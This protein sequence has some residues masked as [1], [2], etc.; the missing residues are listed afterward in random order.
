MLSLEDAHDVQTDESGVWK[1]K[2]SPGA[3]METAKL[4]SDQ[5]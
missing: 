5:N 4:L 2:G 1:R 3:F